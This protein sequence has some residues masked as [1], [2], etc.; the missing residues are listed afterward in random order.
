MNLNF[1]IFQRRNLWTIFENQAKKQKFKIEDGV[2]EKIEK[3]INR[4]KIGRN[5]GNARF[6]TNLFDRLVIIHASNFTDEKGPKN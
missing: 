3:I 6:V 1:L 2:K 4:N 5:F